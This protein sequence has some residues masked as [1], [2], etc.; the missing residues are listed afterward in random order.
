M[1]YGCFTDRLVHSRH[2]LSILVTI[3]FP[4]TMAQMAQIFRRNK[5]NCLKN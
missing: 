2:L 1:A 4:L 5:R 3:E